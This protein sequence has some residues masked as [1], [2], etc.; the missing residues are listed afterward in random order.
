MTNFLILEKINVIFPLF[1]VMPYNKHLITACSCFESFHGANLKN[2]LQRN[3][4]HRV[5]TQ[6]LL[7]VSCQVWGTPGEC[8][9]HQA[10]PHI[11]LSKQ[12]LT[13]A[14]E[15]LIP[16]NICQKIENAKKKKERREECQKMKIE[17]K[18]EEVAKKIEKVVE[19]EAEKEKEKA[20]EKVGEGP[21]TYSQEV[22]RAVAAITS[23][24]AHV[25]L[26]ELSDLT[27]GEDERE[28][29]REEKEA[30]SVN[31]S[32]LSS[33][34]DGTGELAIVIK[35]R[36][37]NVDL[38][39]DEEFN[40]TEPPPR[41][42]RT[43]SPN[44]ERPLP[45]SSPEESPIE[46]GVKDFL[47][48]QMISQAIARRDLKDNNKKLLSEVK[49]LKQELGVFKGREANERRWEA[50]AQVRLEQLKK[51][52]EDKLRLEKLVKDS[53][54]RQKRES[55]E[56]ERERQEWKKAKE[57]LE[58]RVK[59]VQ[60]RLQEKE[61]RLRAA[62]KAKAVAEAA[63][64]EVTADYKEPTSSRLHL[65]IVGNRVAGRCLEQ[66][67]SDASVTCFSNPERK[68]RCVHVDVRGHNVALHV[69]NV[70]WPNQGKLD[71]ITFLWIHYLS[72]TFPY[73]SMR[74]REICST[75]LIITH[76]IKQSF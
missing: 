48:R 62:N 34:S 55:E 33:I 6:R 1:S 50:E 39:S 37:P 40:D 53:D 27:E 72:S 21:L 45:P 49:A 67:S 47:P 4:D 19:K 57:E 14:S 64:K 11:P 56:R 17:K 35:K 15:G 54:E 22:K 51:E 12:D 75:H 28:D 9:G 73:R 2:H 71:V 30:G 68:A 61:E 16:D 29:E 74:R 58:A 32:R 43:S 52:K 38:D 20:V 31:S 23:P 13:V 26:S 63:L 69:K 42:A 76:T 5:V 7:C 65:E 25:L 44:L 70:R 3:P 41:R 36:V 18:K 10:C 66:L 59:E 24:K 60:D 8:F 46:K